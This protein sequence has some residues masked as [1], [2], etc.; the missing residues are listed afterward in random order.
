MV[1]RLAAGT[2]PV[3]AVLFLVCGVFSP[4]A[5]SAGVSVEAEGGI[6]VEITSRSAFYDPA[7][8][9][10][11]AE[12]DVVITRAE[13]TITCSQ[14]DYYVGTGE[15][16][17]K[18][19]V[20][21]TAPGETFSAPE[22][23]LNLDTGR[24]H[25]P[26]GR[27]QSDIYYL[28][29]GPL[30][31][32]ADG[33]IVARDGALTTCNL[34]HPHYKVG[35]SRIRIKPGVRLWATNVVVWVK[36][37]PGDAPNIPVAYVPLYTR[38]LRKGDRVSGLVLSP[39]HSSRKGAFVLGRYNF[40]ATDELYGSV[41]GDYFE[42]LGFGEGLEL[43]YRSADDD[44]AADL[45]G[46]Y[47]D[48]REGVFG[49]EA[50]ER[51]KI[52]LRTRNEMAGDLLLIMRAD[53]FSDARFNDDYKPEELWR[54]FSRTE[55]EN[56]RPEGSVSLVR[57]AEDYAATLYVRKRINDFLDVVEEMPRVAFDL[58][59]RPLGQYGL[60][61]DVDARLS[62][63]INAPD[64][65]EASEADVVVRVS[66]PIRLGWLRAEPALRGRRL[67]YS[68]DD[69]ER[70]DRTMGALEPVLGLTANFHRDY[71]WASDMLRHSI[72]PR[73][74]FS[75]MREPTDRRY[76]LMSFQ[77]RLPD[78]TE[79]MELELVN[80][81][82]RRYA[83][84][85][86]R[87]LV[88]W[89]LSSSYDRTAER[90]RW[91]N[92]ASDLSIWPLANLSIRSESEYNPYIS[93]LERFDNTLTYQGSGW[94][95][96]CGTRV[97]EPEGEDDVYDLIGGFETPLGVKW[98]LQ[99]RARYDTY[100]DRF[101]YRRIGV[102]RDLHCWDAQVVWE[103]ERGRDGEI[104]TTVYVALLLK[105]VPGVRIGGDLR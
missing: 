79:L 17:A 40:D 88:Y 76:K 20:T 50:D 31:R 66:R 89:D 65:V 37:G 46:Y 69:Y 3:W 53:R 13:Y 6:P 26:Q 59:E 82:K 57:H 105:G 101:N 90:R 21:A 85:G 54:G 86:E 97:Y 70:R 32:G 49:D 14:A 2:A 29:G 48:E 103:Q 51:Y 36:A 4:L 104:G 99:A 77:T 27:A 39:G 84:G 38:S 64:G 98:K 68:R 62:R 96:Y 63:L 94:N 58:K 61:G 80:T 10:V 35:A 52:H 72:V 74:T 12:G 93:H 60:Y 22:L 41:F 7:A 56:Q 75:Y 18:G 71:A 102:L 83:S 28:S 67:W 47:I 87:S 19:D 55:L 45:Y 81:L 42:K 25:I 9:H 100:E 11:H 95:F 16:R 34:E 43:K 1:G 33:T 91:S 23:V 44:A 30:D 78:R 5:L 73:A 8:E 15:I 24:V 92:V